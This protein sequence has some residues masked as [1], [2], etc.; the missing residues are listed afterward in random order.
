[1]SEE[2]SA[3]HAYKGVGAPGAYTFQRPCL[4]M[5]VALPL[6]GSLLIGGTTRQDSRRLLR[7]R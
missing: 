6:A 1:M 5:L 4:L 7:P 3:A 2:A